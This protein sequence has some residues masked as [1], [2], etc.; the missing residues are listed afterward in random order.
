MMLCNQ[1]GPS[2]YGG[3]RTRTFNEI[4]EGNST[5]FTTKLSEI[6]GVDL[7][8][9]LG[10]KLALTYTLLAARYGNS[11]IANSDENQFML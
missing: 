8:T 4:F 6:S 11:H 7:T 9:I 3:Y 5:T 1:Y 10:N 2:Y